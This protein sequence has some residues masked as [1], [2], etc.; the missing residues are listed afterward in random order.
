MS[1]D[2]AGDVLT[3]NFPTGESAK[4]RLPRGERGAAGRDG[5]SIRGDRGEKGEKGDAGRDGRDS[6]VKGDKG[7]KGDIGAI[8]KTPVLKIGRVV[9]GEEAAAFIEG[10]PEEPVLNLVLP[11]GERGATGVAGRDGKH[12]KSEFVEVYSVGH[13]PLFHD[14]LLSRH[15]IAD[16]I[17]NLPE[18][19]REENYGA[20]IHFKT[21]DRLVLNNCLEGAVVLDKNESAKVVVVPYQGKFKFTRF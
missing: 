2:L 11:R 7:D 12:G 10:T 18:E 9:T 19:L 13:S 3:V 16:G 6:T 1:L 20:W 8:G 14:D 5:M 15:V 21:L 17:L 4:V